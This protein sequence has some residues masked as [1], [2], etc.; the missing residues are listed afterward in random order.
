M[1]YFYFYLNF[2]YEKNC[3]VFFMVK[4]YDFCSFGLVCVSLKAI[5]LIL[6]HFSETSR[7]NAKFM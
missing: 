4:I 1:I 6:K 5:C 2:I 3:F 7:S